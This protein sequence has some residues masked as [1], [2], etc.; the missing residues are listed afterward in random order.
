MNCL[1]LSHDAKLLGKRL[2]DS[3]SPAAERLAELEVPVLVIVGAHD[4][5]NSLEAANYMTKRIRLTCKVIVED[6]AHLAN[7]DQ[8]DDFQRIVQPFLMLS[9]A[10]SLT[11][12]LRRTSL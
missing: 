8:P 3:V 7:M 5:P 12:Q 4:D 11:W 10:S 6:A 1:R 2:P 9:C